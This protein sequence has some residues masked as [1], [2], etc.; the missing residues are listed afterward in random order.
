MD[1]PSYEVA[2]IFQNSIVIYRVIEYPPSKSE[3]QKEN[4]KNLTRGQ[5]N[6]F[7]SSKSKSKIKQILSPWL[8][9][10]F[11]YRKAKHRPKLKK[12]PYPTFI[13]LTL[14]AEQKHNDCEIKRE[15]LNHFLIN[16]QRKFQVQEYFWICETQENGNLHFHIIADSYIHWQ[17]VRNLWNQC[18]NRLGYI[19]E[20]EKTNHHRNPNSTDIHKIENVD[21]I[22]AYC[23]KYVSKGGGSR[24]IRGKIWSC[25]D[26]IKKLKTLELST[27]SEVTELVN[28]ISNSSKFWKFED[29][30]VT[31]FS[32]DILGFASVHQKS[33]YFKIKNHWSQCLKEIY[34]PKPKSNDIR[35]PEIFDYQ[36][37]KKS[38]QKV[39]PQLEINCPF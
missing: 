16:I 32:G 2:R 38:K 28:K 13:T 39:S 19:D 6:G 25:S 1:L 36:A 4:E 23:M 33:I 10:I 27:D 8:N 31:V 37:Y 5:F 12:N 15:C 7:L 29:S 24:M 26:G 14:P 35:E 18:L 21:S 11:E 20:F 3:K 9:S 34:S 30:K 22:E 17:E